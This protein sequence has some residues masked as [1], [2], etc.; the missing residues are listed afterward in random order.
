M[1]EQAGKHIAIITD[2]WQPQ[3]N[4]VVRTLN[5]IKTQLES[6]GFQVSMI[7]PERSVTI[8]NPFYKEIRLSLFPKRGVPWVGDELRALQPDHIYI[9]TEGPL[10]QAAIRHCNKHQQHY[11]TGFH[12]KFHEYAQQFG[13]PG[14]RVI[15]K[16]L[17]KHTHKKAAA[18]MA[19]TQTVADELKGWGLDQATAWTRGVDTQQF[20]PGDS[21]VYR[22]MKGPI[23]L[24]VGR[25]SFEKNL[26][27]FLKLDLPGTKV[28]VGDGPAM[29]TLK[30]NYPDAVFVGKKQGTELADYY[31]GADVFVFPSRTDTFGNVQTEALA[32]GVPVVAYRS[33]PSKDIITDSKVGVLAEDGALREACLDALKLKQN[34]CADACVSHV[35][36]NYTWE[37]AATVLLNNLVDVHTGKKRAAIAVADRPEAD[38]DIVHDDGGRNPQWGARMDAD[39]KRRG[40]EGRDIR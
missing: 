10:G 37:R 35:A 9:A 29:D 2:A 19:P 13:V 4:G 18:I 1:G 34:G 5:N 23:F 28:I 25:V 7:T 26:D 8:E 20:H 16:M 14:G 39:K 31:R 33:T 30:R 22:D 3:N 17:L 40:G 11:V 24:N 27:D 12:T 36:R 21:A 6:Q 32:C 38:S 15:G